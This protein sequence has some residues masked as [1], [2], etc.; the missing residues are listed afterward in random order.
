MN[1][2][3]LRRGVLGLVILAFVLI[4]ST[5]GVEST[6]AQSGVFETAHQ[7]TLKSARPVIIGGYGDNFNYDGSNVR[8]LHGTAALDLDVTNKTGSVTATIMT[9][10]E[11]GPLFVASS[12]TVENGITKET[13]EYLSGTIELVMD[14]SA[15]ARFE[16]FTWL[17][18]DTGVEAP[19][20][21]ELFNFLAGWA[22]IDVI[23]NGELAYENL[24]GHFMYSEQA[25][26]DDFTIRRDD[27]TIYGGPPTAD[28]TRFVVPDGRE[29]HL[30]SHTVD[31]DPGNF[32]PHTHWIHLVFFDVFVQEAPN[33]ANVSTN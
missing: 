9:T 3:F 12:T 30:V 18:G 28:K 5:W 10:S 13:H 11:S 1:G 23:V 27:G 7:W 19:V 22:P 8:P 2:T 25:R 14:I 31:P 21:P 29:F 24:V 32:P 4:S 17:H 6:Q 33:G 15:N 26:R 20:M 16:E